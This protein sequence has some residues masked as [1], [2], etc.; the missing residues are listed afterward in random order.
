[1]VDVL[2]PAPMSSVSLNPLSQDLCLQSWGSLQNNIDK[3]EFL[4][5]YDRVI[6]SDRLFSCI[7]RKNQKLKPGPCK[8]SSSPRGILSTKDSNKPG[9][10]GLLGRTGC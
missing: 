4:F 1:M 8:L 10:V 2:Y 3:C 6:E 9:S 7:R 5:P